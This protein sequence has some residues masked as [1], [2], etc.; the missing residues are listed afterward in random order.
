MQHWDRQGK[1]S[2]NK[3][4]IPMSSGYQCQASKEVSVLKKW[5]SEQLGLN[6][7]SY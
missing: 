6:R 4:V 3:G 5:K 1:Q 7:V 2:C